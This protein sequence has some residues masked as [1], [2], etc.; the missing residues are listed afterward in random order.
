MPG[1]FRRWRPSRSRPRGFGRA[2]EARASEVLEDY[3]ELIDDLVREGGPARATEIA[4]P[5]GV[6]HVTAVKAVAR[7]EREGLPSR[8]PIAA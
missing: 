2:R 4:P 7:L 8:S 6:S 3:A 1:R 5:P